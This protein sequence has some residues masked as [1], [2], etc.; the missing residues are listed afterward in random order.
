MSR[1]VK[2]EKLMTIKSFEGIELEKRTVEMLDDDKG[3]T[4]RDLIENKTIRVGDKVS[5][6]DRRRRECKDILKGGERLCCFSNT[7]D[8]EFPVFFD[9]ILTVE[10]CRSIFEE[11][12]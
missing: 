6:K 10:E 7:D 4:I 5:V 1:S 11:F 3:I 8:I 9:F 12:K 2:E